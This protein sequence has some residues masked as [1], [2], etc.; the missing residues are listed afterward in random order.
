MSKL[1]TVNCKL[2]ILEIL[3]PPL[4]FT[5]TLEHTGEKGTTAFLRPPFDVEKQF[6]AR[7]VP[8]TG[9]INGTPYRTTLCKAPA[10]GFYCIPVCKGLLQELGAKAGDQVIWTIERD[11]TPREVDV[12]PALAAALRRDKT[13]KTNYDA[14]SYTHRKEIALW[15]AEAK[16]DETRERRLAKA[17]DILQH[18]KK[19]TG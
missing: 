15:I 13:A 6:G 18:G 5:V 17:M 8:V 12:P 9:T 16:K 2:Q 19:W 7:R 11:D 14:M 1:Q 3:M 4:K 10:M